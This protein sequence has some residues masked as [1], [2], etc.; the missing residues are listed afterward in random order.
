MVAI[1]DQFHFT[2]SSNAAAP[3]PDGSIINEKEEKMEDEEEKKDK[4]ISRHIYKA[5]ISIILPS[6][7]SVLTLQV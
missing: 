7:Q 3:L 5:I 1:L 4:D 2:V 6:L